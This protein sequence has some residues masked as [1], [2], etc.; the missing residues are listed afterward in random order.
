MQHM[1]RAFLALVMLICAS[2]AAAQMVLEVIPLRHRTVEEVIPVLQPM[3]V[4][5][6][7]LSGTRGQLIV[8]TTPANLE[9]A[10]PTCRPGN[11]CRSA[12]A[13]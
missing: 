9:A 2:G 11:P 5:D 1:A 10:A 8:R 3:M 7:S 6:S 4:R 13:S 12:I